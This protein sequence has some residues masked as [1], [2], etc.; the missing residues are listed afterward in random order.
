MRS[1]GTSIT[2]ALVC[3]TIDPMNSSLTWISVQHRT[4]PVESDRR[5]SSHIGNPSRV[6]EARILRVLEPWL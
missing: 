1:R 4:H 2:T 5:H 6:F 3:S